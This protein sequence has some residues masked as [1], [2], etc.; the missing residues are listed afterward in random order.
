MHI[1]TR[2]YGGPIRRLAPLVL[3]VFGVVAGLGAVVAQPALPTQATASEEVIVVRQVLVAAPDGSVAIEEESREIADLKVNPNLWDGDRLPVPVRYNADGEPGSLNASGV[4]QT[5]I[6]TWNGAGSGFS[7]IF[8]GSSDGDTGSCLD[9]FE[10]DGANTIRFHQL[11][12]LTLGRTC[13]IFGR[14]KLV[15][16]DMELDSDANWSVATAVPRTAYDLPTT[17]LHELGHAAGLGHSC[18]NGSP[19][20]DSTLKKSVMYGVIG[21]G[22]ARRELTAD[23]LEAIRTAYPPTAPTPGPTA[24]AT[25]TIPATSVI[26]APTQSAPF[27]LYQVRVRAV[28]LSRD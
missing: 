24:T 19:A 23:D 1:R 21:A 18:G 3:L 25:P 8:A 17:V 26:G 10:T 22:E 20:C 15:E 4:L 14:G 2:K 12:G 7:F 6:G 5:A 9:N 13:T 28:L 16:F 11:P 27:P